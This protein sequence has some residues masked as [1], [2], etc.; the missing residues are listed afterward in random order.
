[1]SSSRSG[2]PDRGTSGFEKWICGGSGV[3]LNLKRR[4]V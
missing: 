4:T 2:I 1:V 3:T